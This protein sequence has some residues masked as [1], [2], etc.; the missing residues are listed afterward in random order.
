MQD[1]PLNA[2]RGLDLLRFRITL[3]NIE[4]L[5]KALNIIIV[6]TVQFKSP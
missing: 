5:Y 1:T 4:I 3:N 6:P 2:L